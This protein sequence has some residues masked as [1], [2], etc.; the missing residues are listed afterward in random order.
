M[1]LIMRIALWLMGLFGVAVALALF[2]SGNAGTVTLFWPPYRIDVSLNL[3]LLLLLVLFVLLHLVLGTI[4]ALLSIPAQAREWRIR[5]HEHV[6]NG[7]LLDALS[8]LIAGSYTR[9]KKAVDRVLEHEAATHG[10]H[11]GWTQ[12]PM[13]RVFAHWVAAESAQSLRDLASRDEHFEQALAQATVLEGKN[14]REGLLMRAVR[15]AI[16]DHDA[17]A[18]MT[19]LNQLPAGAARRTL[20]LRLRLKA[21][22]LAGHTDM[23]LETTRLLV[24]HRA[25]S[26]TSA[27]NLL[28][29]LMLESLKNKH[30]AEQILVFWNTLETDERQF[31]EVACAAAERLLRLGG[32]A[33]TA[34]EWLLPIWERMVGLPDGLTMD[35]KLGLV[36]LL[37]FALSS[38]KDTI[39]HDWLTRIVLM[40]ETHLADVVLQY[41]AGVACLHLQLWGKAEQLLKQA[42]T[43]LEDP[44]LRNRSWQ[45]LAGLAERMDDPAMAFSAWQNAAQAYSQASIVCPVGC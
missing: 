11:E 27:Q 4:T 17:D 34:F 40:Q 3:V 16:E 26:Q 13:L 41:L 33:P 10:G 9:A 21:E 19:W 45:M 5:Y 8:H 39:D 7:T 24:K 18:A 22:R 12:A 1:T 20:A 30:D 31:P 2:A 43:R 35:Q 36:Q 38:T 42:L 29:A 15:W 44:C 25:F 37:E 6:M 23:A 32:P 14:S 28:R